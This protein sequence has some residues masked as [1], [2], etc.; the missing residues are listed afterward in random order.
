MIGSVG[1]AQTDIDPTGKV[2]IRGEIWEARAADKIPANAR[3]RVCQV[4]GLT[5]VVEPLAESR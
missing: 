5:L 1:A 3:V 4:E 2:L